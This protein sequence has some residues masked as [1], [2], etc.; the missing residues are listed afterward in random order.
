MSSREHLFFSVNQYENHENSI[1]A[2]IFFKY[3]NAK[4]INIYKYKYQIKIY[5]IYY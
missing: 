5:Y 3:L 2:R 4:V 1:K